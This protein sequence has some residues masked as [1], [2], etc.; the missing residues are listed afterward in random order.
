MKKSR[1]TR[2]VLS[3]LVMLLT[4]VSAK[5]QDR[6]SVSVLRP[7]LSSYTAQIGACDIVDTYLSPLQY[8]GWTA[9]L[10]YERMQA[11]KFDPERWVMRLMFDVE[12]DKSDNPSRNASMWYGGVDFS[13][14][15]MR[16]WTLLYGLTVAAGGG[17]TL[18]VGC[19]YSTRNGNNPASVK[20]AWTV[21][22]TGYV[23][24]NCSV[25]RLPVT[26]RYQPVLPVTG[27]FFAPDYG[28]LYYEIYL[29]NDSGLAHA[30]WWGNYF[31]M[32]NLFTADLHVSTTCLRIGYRNTILS[33]DV[34][35]I[36]SRIVTHSFLLGLSGEWLSVSSRKGLDADARIISAL[37]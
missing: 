28:Q 20:A 11:M 32:E 31:A 1:L 3:A 22:A 15:M 5:T 26:L 4:V 6:D 2:V 30:A 33:T 18:D 35:D 21:D 29:G 34:N 27:V 13:W 24:W 7:V 14:G 12:V 16:R 19:L 8:D 25:G 17:T 23:A 36:T 10:Q 37:Y 9:S